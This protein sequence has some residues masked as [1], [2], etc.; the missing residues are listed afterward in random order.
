MLAKAIADAK[1]NF[2]MQCSWELPKW[3]GYFRTRWLFM[4]LLF[5]VVAVVRRGAGL[6]IPQLPKW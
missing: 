2:F 1:T 3:N 4:Q 5:C 6:T